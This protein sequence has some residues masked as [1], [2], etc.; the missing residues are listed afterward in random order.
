MKKTMTLGFVAA[1][2]VLALG[3]CIFPISW[4]DTDPIDGHAGAFTRVVALEP[5][6]SIQIENVMGDIEI[7]GWDKSEV[8]ITAEEDGD[9]PFRGRIWVPGRRVGMPE[10]EV[11]TIDRVV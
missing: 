1:T 3:A 7:R 9:I 5:G 10:V 2:A 6:G 8:E 4:P 11:E